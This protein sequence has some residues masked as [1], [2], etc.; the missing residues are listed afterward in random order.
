MS[1]WVVVNKKADFAGIG[2]KYGIDQ[3]TARV[4][5]NRDVILDEDIARYIN[6]S[7]GD[8][9]D[10]HL[11]KDGIKLVKILGQAIDDGK[12]IRVI[13][14]YDIDGVMSSHILLSA[15]KRCNANVSVA[16][17]ER[18]KD[19]YGLNIN[20]IDDAYNDGIEVIITCDN[21]IA[22]IDEIDHAKQL[23][24][25]V[26]VTDHHEI[27]FVEEDGIRTYKKSA[28]DAIVNP[29]QKECEYP[30]KDLC[31]AA[32]AWKV[33]Q[34][35]YEEKGIAIEESYDFLENVSFATVGDVMPLLGENRILVREGLKNIRKTKN[36]GMHALIE[37]CQLEQEKIDAYHFGF[38]LGPCINASGR[39]DTAKRALMLFSEESNTKA[40]EIAQELV[41]LNE[42]RK[43]LT[44]QGLDEAISQYEEFYSSDRVIVI[45]LPEVHESIAGII[46][47]RIREKYNKPTFVLT[48]GESEVKG[49]GRSI[50]EYSMYEEMTKCKDL[51]LKFGG[52]PLAAGLSLV[53]ENIDKFRQ[54]INE[55]CTLSQEDMV[56]KVRID[57]PMPVSYVYMDLVREL[58]ILAPFGKDNPRP[59]FADRNLS[60]RRLTILGKNSNVIR[61][62]M[63]SQDGAFISAMLFKDVE[64][65]LEYIKVKFGETTLYNAMAGRDNNIL[66]S[67][68]YTVKIN[69]FKGNESVQFEIQYYQ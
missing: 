43:S 39:L 14:D 58:N 25:T 51:F 32:V 23:G 44:Q 5:R 65:F 64:G 46:A 38:V 54:M 30:F 13:G 47:G 36:T 28:A 12:K 63:V 10:P 20:L 7:I 61:M 3:V 49:S 4:I 15:L 45:Y 40:L 48:K 17:P 16:I 53:E 31:G 8:L 57:V 6:G 26:L 62:E 19:G 59:L 37:R 60:V 2:K 34:L 68:V 42:Q 9:F 21:G 41:S 50:E 67:I 27:P 69:I 29:H 33:V 35:L 52:H 55:K 22:A 24:M 1:K 11:L 66:L 18:I 56:E